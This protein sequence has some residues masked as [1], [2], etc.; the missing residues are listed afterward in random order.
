MSTDVVLDEKIKITIK[1]PSRQK[2]IFLNDDTTPMEFVISVLINIF[3]HS[4]NT[5]HEITMKIHTEGSGVVGI[6][7]HEVAE[8]KAIETATIARQHGFQLQIRLEE[9]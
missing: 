5:A 8:Q 3:K 6:Y 1:E 7:T 4:E 2:V 9:E